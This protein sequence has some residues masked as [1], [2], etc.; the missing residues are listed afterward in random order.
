MTKKSVILLLVL[1]LSMPS[2]IGGALILD[3]WI[4]E[5]EK[6]TIDEVRY[7][8]TYIGTNGV[9]PPTSVYLVS[10]SSRIILSFGECYEENNL[11]LCFPAAEEGNRAVEGELRS[12]KI[13]LTAEKF[14][15]DVSISR[16]IEPA[17]VVIGDVFLVKTTI[18]NKGSLVAEK[19]VFKDYFPQESFRF[20]SGFN[21]CSYENSS[22]VWKGDLGVSTSVICTYQV[23]GLKIT[24]YQSTATATFTDKGA[25]K[26]VASSATFT[27]KK[28]D[29]FFSLVMNKTKVQVGEK[30]SAVFSISN[31]YGFPVRIHEFKVT[32]PDGL[33]MGSD[34]RYL[35]RSENF[36]TWEGT[37]NGHSSQNFSVEIEAYKPGTFQIRESATY[38]ANSVDR[39]SEE[40]QTINST[41]SE[42]ML[43]TNLRNSYAPNENA[44]FILDIV[45]PGLVQYDNIELLVKSN[46]SGL[47]VEKV[48]PLIK[49]GETFNAVMNEFTAPSIGAEYSVDAEIKYT[50]KWSSTL[51]KELHKKFRV[52]A[53]ANSSAGSAKAAA[54]ESSAR[55]NAS[56]TAD[57]DKQTTS[58]SQI[59]HGVSNKNKMFFLFGTA[60]VL[61]MIGVIAIG[62][63]SKRKKPMIV[64][65]Y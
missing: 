39:V 4:Y 41:L 65:K 30:A 19:M 52:S 37:I 12:Y 64:Y 40:E 53:A 33:M 58:D 44:R 29:V 55:N 35:K 34:D 45:N 31:N 16:V 14:G 57:S 25:T 27:V 50:A 49:A 36:F 54:N 9:N 17:S 10:D 51:S 61:A 63:R 62:V 20:I 42:L 21:G 47:T 23:R 11:F 43:Q 46:I 15:P 1:L 22:M 26:K 60:I 18:E 32:V 8:I 5:D 59:I 56:K 24:S 3:K 48:I 38:N 2:V 6:V 28:D 7:S 13:H